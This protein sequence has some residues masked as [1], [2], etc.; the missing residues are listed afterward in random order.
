MHPEV[1]SYLKTM[2]DANEHIAKFYHEAKRL[3]FL[4]LIDSISLGSSR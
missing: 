2:K 3:W 1:R 4:Y